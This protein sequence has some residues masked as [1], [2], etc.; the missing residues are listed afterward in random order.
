MSKRAGLYPRNPVIRH[1]ALCGQPKVILPLN[2]EHMQAH[3]SR[4]IAYVC[5]ECAE[6]VRLEVEAAGEPAGQPK[7]TA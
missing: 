2:E 3:R 6:R 4:Q 5:D 7:A 1:C